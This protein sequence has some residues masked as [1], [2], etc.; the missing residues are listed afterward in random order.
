MHAKYCPNKCPLPS[1]L[2]ELS[3]RLLPKGDKTV[4]TQLAVSPAHLPTTSMEPGL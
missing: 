3:V 1:N 2:E 4:G